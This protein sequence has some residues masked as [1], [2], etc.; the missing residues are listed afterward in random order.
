[1][2]CSCRTVGGGRGASRLVLALCLASVSAPAAQPA[3]RF[4]L[5]ALFDAAGGPGWT[6]RTNWRSGEPVSAWYGVTTDA[7]GRVTRLELPG[8]NLSGPIPAALGGL[9]RLEVLDLGR[10]GELHDRD[11]S[12]NALTGPLP[13]ELGAL[14]ALR[15]LRLD[16]NELTGE[17]P[18][19]LGDL[20]ALAALDL[21]GNGLTDAIPPGIAN[22]TALRELYLSHNGLTGAIPSGI[23]NLTALAVLDLQ[24]NRL[25]GA[26]PSG[27]GNLTRLWRLSL[28][29]NELTGVIP[30]GIGNLTR[31]SYLDLGDNRLSGAIPPQIGNL[32]VLG[33]MHLG[34]N[35]LTGEIPAEI[36]N[37]TDLYELYLDR[38]RLT[39]EIP[40][41]LGNTGLST[42]SLARNAL[43]GPVPLEMGNLTNLEFLDLHANALAWPLPRSMTLLPE[44]AVVWIH[45]TRLCA[46]YHTWAEALA[47]FRGTVCGGG[48][49]PFTAD[50]PAPGDGVRG[51][52]IEELREAV[53][54]ARTLC[55]LSRAPWTNRTLSGLP[56]RAVH[57]G[58][59]RSFLA[60]AYGACSL[61]PAP[62]YADPEIVPRVT[63]VAALHFVELRSAAVR[64]LQAIA[65]PQ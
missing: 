55:G 29:R 23:G 1:M 14:S 60:E 28:A 6:V 25:S 21:S 63:P 35:D 3:D 52:D 43:S 2:T 59:L 20:A 49:W 58:E 64:A 4:V 18:G 57:L 22:L 7:A 13:A 62:T 12:Y 40:P 10:A 56:I 36:G 15:E 8:N 53:D 34:G 24:N 54:L 37:L 26:I 45:L 9:S 38:N 51:G 47:D 48:P 5:E 16:D 46:P 17:I 32:T 65:G 42:L 19:A 44:L 30:S 31:L 39:G 33:R 41:A 50:V 27:I 61:T 11:V